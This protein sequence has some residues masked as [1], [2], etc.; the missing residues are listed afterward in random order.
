MVEEGAE[1]D[2]ETSFTKSKA[3][4]TAAE[5]KRQDPVSSEGEDQ[6]HSESVH[7][8]LQEWRKLESPRVS[9]MVSPRVSPRASPRG[10]PIGSPRAMPKREGAGS[11]SLYSKRVNRVSFMKLYN[12]LMFCILLDSYC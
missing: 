9:P 11:P 4:S 3:I 1:D 7:K 2:Q 8:R 6:T 5:R 12:L 10:S